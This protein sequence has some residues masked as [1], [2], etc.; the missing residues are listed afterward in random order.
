M[1]PARPLPS[2]LCGVVGGLLCSGAHAGTP[3]LVLA[4]LL[5]AAASTRAA[6]AALG[7]ALGV[8]L[9]AG[10]ARGQAAWPLPQEAL[11]E[12]TGT[13]RSCDPP[14][15]SGQRFVLA[16]DAPRGGGPQVQVRW[17]ARDA[18]TLAPGDR[19]RA[20]LEVQDAG[21][22]G[23][24]GLR[25]PRPWLARQGLW[26]RATAQGE[27]AV[28]LLG[29]G[30]G[31]AR[32][33][34][35]A[36]EQASAALS[37]HLRPA[38]A[39]LARA[40]LL[41]DRGA[42]ARRD[43][44]AFRSAGQGHL[45]AVSG[46]HVVLVL[47]T[48]LVLARMLGVRGPWR[49]AAGLIT[50]AAYVP[51][52]GAAP[53]AVRSGLTASTW[54]LA[55]LGGREAVA[56]D[57]ICGTAL[58]MLLA[59]PAALQDAGFTLSFAAVLGIECLAPRLAAGL[60]AVPIRI[61]GVLEPSRP[62][63]RMALCVALAAWLAGAPLAQHTFGTLAP[64]SV[65]VSLLAVPLAA[66]LL[67]LAAAALA[68]GPLPL[69][70][71]GVRGL[72]A[73]TADLLR[74]LLD[75][76]E[77]AGLGLLQ[78]PQPGPAW[79][80]AA[81]GLLALACAGPPRL[82][83]WS[84]LGLGALL[85]GALVPHPPAVPR[86]PEAVALEAPRAQAVLLR[87]PDARNV[88]LL[89][90]GPA[91]GPALRWEVPE[92]LRA[93]CVT[94]LDLLWQA[95]SEGRVHRDAQA[96]A[97]RLQAGPA[98]VDA[99]ADPAHVLLSGA[100]GR[101]E[102]ATQAGRRVVDLVQPGQRTRLLPPPVEGEGAWRLR[103]D[104]GTAAGWQPWGAAAPAHGLGEYP[105]HAMLAPAPPDAAAL[106]LLALALGGFAIA[107]VRPLRWLAPGGALAAFVLGMAATATLGWA[108]LA[109]LLAPFIV[110]TLLGRLP[111][112]PREAGRSARQV[113][114]N[115]LPALLGAGLALAGLREAGAAVLV[116]S[117]AC[118]GA[119]T[120]ATEVG[121]RYGGQPRSMWGGRPLD[122][123]TSG[124]VTRA[125]LAASLLGAM[126]SPLAF[127]CVAGLDLTTQAW[128]ATAGVAGALLD[129]LLG[130][131]LQFR[132]RAPD[133]RVLEQRALDGVALARVRGW[134]VLD[135]DAVNLASGLAA[136]LLGWALVAA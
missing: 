127:G 44:E 134:R 116:A 131:T 19:V 105:A 93:L 16:L 43:A 112:R 59:D 17:D 88:L 56:L 76:P 20:V 75:L 98:R 10:L 71:E 5:A 121:T 45:V 52:A 80:V 67:G 82:L 114:C 33:L 123:G 24:P 53:S 130:A 115:G 84:L 49:L 28:A 61:A 41:G 94:R 83:R 6:A 48:V 124:G 72:F 3:L 14:A 39:G 13:V 133:G 122:T 103:T 35:Q 119:D 136:G 60:G 54:L 109:A 30:H 77:P 113:A 86:A 129:S 120:C 102:A 46:Q 8:L 18:P 4:G 1:A 128:L 99:P 85:L 118:L 38:D 110:A 50:L 68:L 125:G 107:C 63:V 36:R 25:D 91:L 11:V 106:G 108:A 23:S 29:R 57:V 37:R 95:N 87:L 78:G 64:A 101:L 58:A 34:A 15:P 135:N 51:L 22:P 27:E 89:A 81:L 100:W 26:A 66:A 70:A 73:A 90:G 126:L 42:L 111:G 117:L 12:A 47:G 79:L 31:A 55:R 74:A 62:R 9:G 65:P 92:A 97:A 21:R 132:G 2:A 40:L 7:F 69:V 104:P 96:L 32:L